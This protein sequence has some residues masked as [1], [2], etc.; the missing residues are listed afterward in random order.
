VETRVENLILGGEFDISFSAFR[1][2]HYPGDLKALGAV[3]GPAEVRIRDEKPTEA[4]VDV[5]V[6]PV[7][8]LPGA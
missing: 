6:V 8:G 1:N 4:F 3:T 5:I 7:C 2:A